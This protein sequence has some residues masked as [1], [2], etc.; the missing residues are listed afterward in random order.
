MDF[1]SLANSFSLKC[2]QVIV[3]LPG[4]VLAVQALCTKLI[5]LL[6]FDR[7]IL[8]L[9]SFK[10]LVK[11]L[12]VI[13]GYIFQITVIKCRIIVIKERELNLIE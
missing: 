5:D 13:C 11:V 9:Y 7:F 10:N 3:F 4:C 1:L 6:T 8:T 12:L 2:F